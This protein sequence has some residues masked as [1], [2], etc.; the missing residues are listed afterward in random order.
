[1]FLCLDIFCSLKKITKIACSSSTQFWFLLF[2]WLICALLQ[3]NTQEGMEGNPA[4]G[5]MKNVSRALAVASVPLT[6]N[7]P[8]V[9]FWSLAWYLLS[10]WYYEIKLFSAS[11][12]WKLR[13][14]FGNGL[15]KWMS[16]KSCRSLDPH[17]MVALGS[18]HYPSLPSTVIW[19]LRICLFWSLTNF[20]FVIAGCILLLGY[21][22]LVF[23]CLW[24]RWVFQVLR[25]FFSLL[26]FCVIFKDQ[27]RTWLLTLFSSDVHFNH[28]RYLIPYLY[29]SVESS[30]GKKVF[31][32][33]RSTRGTSNYWCK[34][35]SLWS[36]FSTQTTLKRQKGTYPIIAC[37]TTK[38]FT[39]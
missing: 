3:C 10:T 33:S 2:S 9:I 4:A 32:C 39:A 17:K 26:I 15:Y 37:W 28:L 13:F 36:V 8:K 23:A 5:T 25:S 38:A 11:A 7:F 19:S 22:Q 1:M 24:V 31:A 21:I 29:F 14:S 12:S 18:A 35:F 34:I 30:W 6:M 27:W 16:R 20:V